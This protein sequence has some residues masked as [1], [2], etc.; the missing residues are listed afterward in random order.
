MSST[1]NT[2]R[3][4]TQISWSSWKGPKRS[5]T[6]RSK[7]S[8]LRTSCAFT[9][10]SHRTPSKLRWKKALAS[11]WPSCQPTA[12]CTKLSFTSAVFSCVSTISESSLKTSWTRPKLFFRYAHHALPASQMSSIGAKKSELPFYSTLNSI[13]LFSDVS[14][15]RS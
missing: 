10:Y 15:K 5:R 12:A 6:T 8:K 9:T 4:N 1:S 2:R 13:N 3:T 14:K 11:N 7:Y